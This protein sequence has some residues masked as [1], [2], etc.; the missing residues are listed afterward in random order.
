MIRLTDVQAREYG[1][2]HRVAM[3]TDVWLQLGAHIWP[4]DSRPGVGWV[5]DQ[6]RIWVRPA[7]LRFLWHCLHISLLV[8]WQAAGGPRLSQARVLVVRRPPPPVRLTRHAHL[9]YIVYSIN[10]ARRA[11]PRLTRHAHLKYKV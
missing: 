11:A 8:G 7:A 6:L 3:A 10:A 9:K 5:R 4:T 1:A 2:T